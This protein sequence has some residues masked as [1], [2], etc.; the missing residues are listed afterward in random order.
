MSIAKE[1]VRMIINSKNRLNPGSEPSHNFTFSINYTLS[2]ISEIYIERVEIPFSYYTINTSN[3][4]LTFNSGADSITISPG[5][6]T[7][8][9]LIVEMTEKLNLAFIAQDP[10]VTFNSTTLKMTISKSSAFIVD[11]ILSV[12]TST[13]APVL[14]FRVS[15]SS[16]TSATANSAMNISGPNYILI[17]SNYLTRFIQH[18]TLFSTSAYSSV[19][20]A[21]PV[22]SSPGDTIIETPNLPIKFNSKTTFKL[23]DI[24]DVQL[25]D[26]NYALLDLN[27]LD[28]AMQLILITE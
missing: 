21:V 4:V 3:N 23:T 24:I 27:G 11:S 14:G 18:K 9:S 16:A 17:S 5:N 25:Y 15:S 7:A 26:E 13:I 20:W 6:Y 8:S 28:W 2:R 19:F 12:P 10:V 1:R 22:S